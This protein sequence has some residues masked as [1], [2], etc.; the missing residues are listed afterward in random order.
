VLFA[1][2]SVLTGL[3]FF[4]VSW[5]G[6]HA[7]RG[8]RVDL[9]KHLHRL[10][11][12]FYGEHDAG[13]LMS[14]ITNDSETIQQALGFALV[15]VL[16]GLLLIVWIAYNMFRENFAYALISL[17]VVPFM[18]LATLW[19]SGQARKAPASRARRWAMSTPS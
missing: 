9:F 14:R 3:T 7:L 1:A 10:S 16:S 19:L 11:L 5:S 12:G 6:Q 17:A 8:I 4:T 18:F 2:G 13:N 15:Q